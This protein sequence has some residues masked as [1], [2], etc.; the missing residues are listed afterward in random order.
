MFKK[1]L[2]GLLVLCMVFG[3]SSIAFASN[4]NSV[5]WKTNTVSLSA[6]DFYITVDGTNYAPNTT[7][8]I[9]SDPGNPE[10]TTFETT[11]FQN[12]VEMRMNLYFAANSQNYW[13]S[14][15]RIYNGKNPANWIVLDNIKLFQS[16]LEKTVSKDFFS[17]SFSNSATI[18]FKNLKLSTT[19]TKAEKL[20]KE[21]KIPI[22]SELFLKKGTIIRS[23]NIAFLNYPAS[24]NEPKYYTYNSSTS[25]DLIVILEDDMWVYLSSGGFYTT[26]FKNIDKYLIDLKNTCEITPL[27]NSKN[28]YSPVYHMSELE[29]LKIQLERA[30]AQIFE[31]KKTFYS[32][33]NFF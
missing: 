33:E 23:S 25:N 8:T 16:P 4:G 9:N 7:T 26:K 32:P 2:M 19:F 10:Y 31:L 21:I 28:P 15:A 1:G 11:W 12:G 5:D 20:D 17:V 29:S 13:I 27:I 6:D 24:P 18:N 30:K 3:L 22:C 14:E